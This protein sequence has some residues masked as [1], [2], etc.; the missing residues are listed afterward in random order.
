MERLPAAVADR[1]HALMYSERSAAY[2]QIDIELRLVGA[3]GHLE[4]YG[5]AALCL[6]EPAVEQ[7]Y[8]LEGL[9]PPTEADDF[10]PSVEL[11]AGRA[12]DLHFHRGA[13]SIWILLLDVTVERDAARRVQ[14]R[15]NEMALLQEKEA[16]A[17]R[18]LE[19]ANSALLEAQT[20]LEAS[21]DLA[22]R[23]LE[24]KQIELAEA[25][26]LQLALAPPSYQGV[27]GTCALTV[28]VA[29]EPAKEVGGDL[30][31]H[32]HIGNDLLILLVGDV[33]D[34]GAGAALVMAR[35]HALFRGIMTR[36]DAYDL[37]RAP[38]EA[39]RLVNTTLAAAN[40]S[41]MFVTLLIAAFDG[42]TRRLTYTRAGHVPPFLRRANG[43]VE[44]LG[45]LGG[46]PLGI[47]EDAA[48]RSAG[49]TLEPG[50]ELLIV[51][52]GITEAM[53]RSQQLFGEV[54]V[55]EMIAQRTSSETTLLHRLLANVRM[56]EAGSPQSDDIAAIAL[57]IGM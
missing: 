31:D 24:R 11:G 6:G 14:Q 54:R 7:A 23:E 55:A 52:D 51:T 26:T 28:D 27:V 50:D 47:N 33:S 39:V 17:N 44:R 56:F 8:F 22:R 3:G 12:T 32:F 4:H 37:F 13:G 46:L 18:R 29:L 45:A 36:P 9:L 48:Y 1:L 34:K 41:C 42:V 49:V 30:V 35:T 53:D 21:R 2:L 40:A 38:E 15:A 20:A 25:R 5:L 57:H 10:V 19:A 16:L 43:I